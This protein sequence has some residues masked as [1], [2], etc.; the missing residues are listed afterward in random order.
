MSTFEKLASV[1]LFIIAANLC[2]I[3]YRMT[4][5]LGITTRWPPVGTARSGQVPTPDYA[6]N[7][8]TQLEYLACGLNMMLERQLM[9]EERLAAER[10]EAERLKA[11]QEA[12][13]EE[14]AEP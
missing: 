13:V 14:E 4:P 11:E 7:I 3:T 9:A 12:A 10:E 5:N 6:T 1:L 2:Y 8:P